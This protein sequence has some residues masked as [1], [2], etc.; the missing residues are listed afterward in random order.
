M[1]DI[2]VL[3]LQAK[4]KYLIGST[5]KESAKIIWYIIISLGSYKTGFNICTPFPFLQNI[6]EL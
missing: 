3:H 5:K 1:F 4:K 6:N 2:C